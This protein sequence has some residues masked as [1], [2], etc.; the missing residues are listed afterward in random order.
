MSSPLRERGRRACRQTTARPSHDPSS[1]PIPKFVRA[2]VSL[3]QE[4]VQNGAEDRRLDVVG[5]ALQDAQLSVGQR[6]GE[7]RVVGRQIGQPG[8]GDRVFLIGGEFLHPFELLGVSDELAHSSIR[9]G[10][11]RF[12]N[13]EEVDF[14]IGEVTDAVK[15]LRSISP[16]YEMAG[17][18]KPHVRKG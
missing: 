2:F 12:N 1:D 17:G 15:R 16:A 13:E 14:A 5:L 8:L 10:L 18:A 11:G 7:G 9:F 4:L 6:V 3:R